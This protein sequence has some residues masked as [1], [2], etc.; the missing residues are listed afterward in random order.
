MRVT[1]RGLMVG[2][3][4]VAAVAAL[5]LARQGSHAHVMGLIRRQ[6]GRAVAEDPQTAEFA[7]DYVRRRLEPR[8]EGPMVEAFLDY[9]LDRTGLMRDKVQ[10]LDDDIVRSFV[11]STNVLDVADGRARLDY[12]GFFDPYDRPCQNPLTVFAVDSV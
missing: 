8:K 9:G 4:A 7:R 2:T 5:P 6:F 3:A 1:R 11:Q 10:E 12:A